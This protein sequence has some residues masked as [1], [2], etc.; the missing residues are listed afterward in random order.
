LKWLDL[1]RNPI[2]NKNHAKQSYGIH[3]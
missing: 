3:I 2:I 1:E